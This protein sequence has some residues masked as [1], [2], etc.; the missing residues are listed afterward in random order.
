MKWLVIALAPW[1]ALP[2]QA[3][4]FDDIKTAVTGHIEDYQSRSLPD[5]V[6]ESGTVLR[7]N[8]FRTE[9]PGQD[10]L[11]YGRGT[12]ELIEDNGVTYLQLQID[13]EFGL[14]P[15]LHLYVSPAKN[16]DTE[17]RFKSTEQIEI[18]RLVKGEG[19]SYY[20]LDQLS[21]A[22]LDGIGSVTV[23]CKQ[24]SEFMASTDL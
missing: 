17:A 20:A 1:T 12:V 15:D 9:D 13:V 16:I 6:L 5:Q 11:H 3:G 8:Q 24:F 23:W 21:P 18:G 22:Q 4:F 7:S 14:A 19:A 10:R 2:A